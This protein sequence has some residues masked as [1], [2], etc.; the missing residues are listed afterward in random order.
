MKKQSSVNKDLHLWVLLRITAHAIGRARDKELLQYDL[1]SP[2]AA[3]LSIIRALGKKAT[4]TTI[5]RQLLREAHSVS[6]LLSRMEKD[7]YLRKVKDLDRKNLIRVEM[8][9][10]GK[11]V[12]SQSSKRESIHLVISSLSKEEQ[13]QLASYLKKIR[14][15]AFK[16]IGMGGIHS[17]GGVFPV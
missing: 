15:N 9:E 17:S 13:R 16:E 10:K 1:T 2:Q 14:D 7:G 5:A 6:G 12:Y 3:V 8:T 11:K 4:P